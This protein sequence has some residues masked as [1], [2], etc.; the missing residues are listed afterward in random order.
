MDRSFNKIE[1]PQ[2][3]VASSSRKAIKVGPQSWEVKSYEP[4][5]LQELQKTAEDLEALPSNS[6]LE[7]AQLMHGQ[8]QDN[9]VISSGDDYRYGFSVLGA[10][11]DLNASASSASDQGT[12]AGGRRAREYNESFYRGHYEWGEP[13]AGT[14]FLGKFL[15]DIANDHTSDMVTDSREAW[16]VLRQIKPWNW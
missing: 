15:I 3:R 1:Q 2:E 6:R 9:D 5:K 16:R 8:P 4:Q 12:L 13:K 14:S 7:L 10:T 11:P